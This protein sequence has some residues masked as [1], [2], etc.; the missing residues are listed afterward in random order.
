MVLG[1]LELRRRRPK[2]RCRFRCSCNSRRVVAGVNARLQLANPIPGRGKRQLGIALEALLEATLVELCVTEGGKGRRQPSEHADKP[3]LPGHTVADET[4]RHLPYEFESILGPLLGLPARISGA[5]K[6]R[7]RA[8]VPL[9]KTPRRKRFS[10]VKRAGDVS[11]V[12]TSMVALRS[13]SVINGNS[14]NDS[15]GAD[16]SRC[17]S[18]SYASR[19]SFAV[20][21]SGHRPSS[22]RRR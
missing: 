7:A 21:R 19:T 14:A 5:E 2:K 8:S 20:A 16:P 15:I 6:I 13:A 3:E 10:P 12:S 9:R 18:R 11:I 4:E 1:Q 22:T 17:S